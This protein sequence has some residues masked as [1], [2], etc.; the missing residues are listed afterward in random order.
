MELP[1]PIQ[2]YHFPQVSTCSAVQKISHLFALRIFTATSLHR[3]DWLSHYSLIVN[4]TSSPYHIP[5]SP[6]VTGE[7][8]GGKRI[9]TFWSQ[10]WVSVQPAPILRYSPKTTLLIKQKDKLCG[11]HPLEIPRILGALCQEKWTKMKYIF[12]PFHWIAYIFNRC[13]SQWKG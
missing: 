6:E 5:K 1:H 10:A 2:K 9:Q 13:A 3:H 4:S 11:S 8:R 12:Y 7:G